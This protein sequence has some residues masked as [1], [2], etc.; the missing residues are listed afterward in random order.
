MTWL[1]ILQL[2]LWAVVAVLALVVLALMRQIGAIY[3]RISPAGIN[4][5]ETMALNV[6]DL[7]EKRTLKAISGDALDL[8]GP[9]PAKAQLVAFVSPRCEVCQS[10]SPKL[11]ALQ[12]ALGEKLVTTLAVT[13]LENDGVG[14]YVDVG[15]DRIVPADT[16]ADHVGAVHLPHILVLREDGRIAVNAPVT[17]VT[18]FE[19]LT[20]ALQTPTSPQSSSQSTPAAPKPQ[21]MESLA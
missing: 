1:V 20:S 15:F 9:L 13:D 16:L 10:I 11:A 5:K 8:G 17:S 14:K 4:P 2:G 12:T 6:G 7:F 18:E 19:R 3:E 21:S